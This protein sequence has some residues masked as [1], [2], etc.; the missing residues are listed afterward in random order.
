MSCVGELIL[1]G[2]LV[3][4]SITSETFQVTEQK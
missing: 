3:K 4:I 2:E 1:Y